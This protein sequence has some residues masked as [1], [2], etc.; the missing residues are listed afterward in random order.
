[1]SQTMKMKCNDLNLLILVINS[2]VTNYD[3][4]CNDFNIV[5]LTVS[6]NVTN[7]DDECIVYT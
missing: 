5:A 7:Y 6:Q 3:M 4:K 1:M 2:N